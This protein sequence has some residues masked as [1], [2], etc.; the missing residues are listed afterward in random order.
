MGVSG[1]DKNPEFGGHW[2]VQ[3]LSILEQYLDAYTTALKNKPFKLVYIDAFAGTGRIMA[4]PGEGQATD[5]RDSREFIAGSA[6]RALMVADR[7]FDKLIFVEKDHL[8]LG[9]LATLCQE[10]GDRSIDL[11]EEDA[12][13]FLRDLRPEQYGSW[14]G[15]LFADPFGTQMEWETVKHLASLERLDM[16]LLFPVGAIA[17]MLPRSKN[18]DEVEPTWA[19]RLSLVYGGDDWRRL[20]SPARQRSFFDEE[21]VER[22]RGVAG[23]LAI[24]KD[25]LAKAFGPRFLPDSRTLTNS[26]NSPLFEFIFC[27]GHPNG[28]SIAK[29]IAKHIVNNI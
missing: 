24:Y 20:Y 22:A 26:R 21:A 15:V 14:R 5:E 18:P 11:R 17:R 7:V 27:A 6:E 23:L 10:H 25:H 1:S 28:A 3:K 12:N 19:S 13:I 2:T 8:R 9:L 16:W 4:E 29:R